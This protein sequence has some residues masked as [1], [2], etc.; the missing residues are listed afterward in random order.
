VGVG[1]RVEH[2]MVDADDLG[3]VDRVVDETDGH[4]ALPQ[5][6]DDVRD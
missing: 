3:R 6:V 1:E 4:R 2:P 5:A